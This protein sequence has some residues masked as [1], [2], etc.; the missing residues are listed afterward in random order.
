[1][2][3]DGKQK[4][5]SRSANPLAEEKKRCSGSTEPEERPEDGI[6]GPAHN[7]RVVRIRARET[8]EREC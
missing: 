1:M 3:S 7:T 5:K 6:A 2:N 8:V 4:I